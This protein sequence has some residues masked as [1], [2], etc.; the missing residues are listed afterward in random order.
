MTRY[1]HELLLVGTK[2]AIPAPAM[3]TQFPSVIDAPIGKHSEKPVQFY[4]LIEAYFPTL[5][6]I[7]LN[8]RRAR[9]GW[10]LWGN[11]APLPP[12]D[13][14]TGEV[15]EAT[16]I[17]ENIPNDAVSAAFDAAPAFPPTEFADLRKLENSQPVD[18]ALASRL[19]AYLTRGLV[20]NVLGPW[21]LTRAGEIRLAVVQRERLARIA[22]CKTHLD[23]QSFWDWGDLSAIAAGEHVDGGTVR[24]LVGLDLVVCSDN[25]DIAL[26]DAGRARLAELD[27]IVDAAAPRQIDLEELIDTRKPVDLP[28]FLASKE[29]VA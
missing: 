24:S 15:I 7:E 23:Q 12:H 3:G 29:T 22:Q 13:P 2:G 10:E 19:P 17:P 21:R 1:D 25:G 20:T 27:G 26:T 18:E 8:A 4:E 16:N 6:K 28:L 11:E 5:P 9:D 14:D